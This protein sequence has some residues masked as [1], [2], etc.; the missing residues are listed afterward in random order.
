MILTKNK[1]QHFY[2]FSEEK[3]V[4]IIL[5]IFWPLGPNLDSGS[6][7]Y[8][9][10]DPQQHCFEHLVATR[11]T[12]TTPYLAEY[13]ESGELL[14]FPALLFEPVL[15]TVRQTIKPKQKSCVILLA[16]PVFFSLLT[17]TKLHITVY[18]M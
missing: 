3:K 9:D 18:T 11:C 4:Q 1:N 6:S 14:A 17:A 8:P 10:L 13:T 15:Q 12:S 16:D 5:F 2:K 7:P